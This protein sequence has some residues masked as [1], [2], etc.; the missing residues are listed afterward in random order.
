[1]LTSMT[2]GF[3]VGAGTIDL[4]RRILGFAPAG[5]APT[6]ATRSSPAPSP[7][8]PGGGFTN[9]FRQGPLAAQYTRLDQLSPGRGGTPFQANF[10]Y[11]L[12]RSRAGSTLATTTGFPV[13]TPSTA[14]NSMVSGSVRFSPTRH[15]TLSWQTSY[16]FTSGEF[17]DHVVRLDRD[18]MTGA[19]RSRSCG[20]ERQLPLQLLPAVDRRTRT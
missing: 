19:H 18:C 7:T 9:A 14:S 4:F 10:S 3:S 8:N 6:S 20:V 1:M 2:F 17:S 5:R 16:N 13:A 15:W 11:S 12:Q